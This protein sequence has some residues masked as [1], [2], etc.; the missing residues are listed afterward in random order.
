MGKKGRRMFMSIAVINR[1]GSKI[2][3]DVG[4]FLDNNE[5]EK[6]NFFFRIKRNYNLINEIKDI[7]KNKQYKDYIKE[8]IIKNAKIRNG[9]PTIK[10]T[11][12][13]PNDIVTLCYRTNGLSIENILEEYPV[14]T[15]ERQVTFTL[16]YYM[17]RKLKNP[18]I[19]FRCILGI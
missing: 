11:R 18:F 2:C 15:D 9:C 14:L 19:K 3:S 12:I 5:L 17:E 6:D 10:G 4:T 7:T 16:L 8:N 1:Y 13:T